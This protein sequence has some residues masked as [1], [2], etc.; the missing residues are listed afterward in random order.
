MKYLSL[1]V[2]L[3]SFTASAQLSRSYS[4][5]MHEDQKFKYA[6]SLPSN[7]NSSISYSVLIGPGGVSKG[8]DPNF[9]WEGARSSHGWILVEAES[10]KVSSAN[11]ASLIRHLRSQFKVSGD[12][13]FIMGFSANSDPTFKHVLTLPDLFHGVIGVPGHPRT[14]NEDQLMKLKGMSILNICG[15]NDSYWLNQ[16]QVFEKIYDK[17]GI[18]NELKIIPDGDHVL[19]PLKGDP[20]LELIEGLKM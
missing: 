8:E 12:K 5:Y 9:Y 2:L 11:M 6:Y 3:I 18:E 15:S 7:F 20:F 1:T 19:V 10:W 14:K 16:A 13:V 17:M 4:T